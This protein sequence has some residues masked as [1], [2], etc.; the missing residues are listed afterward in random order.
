MVAT[1][2][3]VVEAGGE[4]GAALGAAVVAAGVSVGGAVVGTVMRIVDV[5]E[6]EAD[7]VALG[8]G[9]EDVGSTCA[10]LPRNRTTIA[11]TVTR[12]PATA[13]SNRSIPRGP[14]RGGGTILVVSPDGASWVMPPCTH[15]PCRS[16][17][18]PSGG[19]ARGL[20]ASDREEP[21]DV[22]QRQRPSQRRRERALAFEPVDKSG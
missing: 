7:A 2:G 20:D 17:D 12:L 8:D 3:R 13:A 19:L 4:V 10:R 14:R 6:A 9:P 11:R 22:E 15:E 1:G 21:L 18:Q 16:V 5:G